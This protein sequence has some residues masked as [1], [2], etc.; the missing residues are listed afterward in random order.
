M[1]FTLLSLLLQL[2][3]SLIT[4]ERPPEPALKLVWQDEFNYTGL[5]DSTKWNYETGE[6]KRQSLSITNHKTI[7]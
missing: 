6:R 5:P 2:A 3:T 4:S 1:R 7:I